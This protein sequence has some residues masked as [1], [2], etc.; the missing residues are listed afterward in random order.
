MKALTYPQLRDAIL[1]N[2]M[3]LLQIKMLPRDFPVTVTVTPKG[4]SVAIIRPC[5]ATNMSVAEAICCIEQQ[6]EDL[7]AQVEALTPLRS[8]PTLRLI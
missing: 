5:Q 3:V 2:T 1:Q 7:Q 8:R 6:L 4:E